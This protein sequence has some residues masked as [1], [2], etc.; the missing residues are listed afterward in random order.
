MIHY[1]SKSDF[2]VAHDC[3]TKL[4][5]KKKGYPSLNEQDLYLQHLA[6]GGYMV[7]KLATLYYQS[8]ILIDTGTD[9]NEAIKETKRHCQKAKV[10]LFEAAIESKGKLVRVDILQLQIM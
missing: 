5:Y 8:G 10:T 1:L 4:Y 9:H 7:G 2:K 6:R 3:P